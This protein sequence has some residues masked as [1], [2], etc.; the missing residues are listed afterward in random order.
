M[1]RQRKQ[2]RAHVQAPPLFL[3]FPLPLPADTANR[4]S[5][6]MCTGQSAR[7]PERASRTAFCVENIKKNAEGWKP[8]W[9]CRA[10]VRGGGKVDVWVGGPQFLHV[11]LKPPHPP[12]FSEEQ[13]TCPNSNVSSAAVYKKL[14][15]TATLIQ[16]GGR[17]IINIQ[18]CPTLKSM[19]N[20]HEL[21]SAPTTTPPPPFGKTVHVLPIH[22]FCQEGIKLPMQSPTNPAPTFP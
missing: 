8:A 13:A 2:G 18:M 5:V 4:S 15:S 16:I 9:A 17:A 11:C 10:D 19:Q 6:A 20:K 14:Q 21:P 12:T 1:I 22:Y 7:F 3:P